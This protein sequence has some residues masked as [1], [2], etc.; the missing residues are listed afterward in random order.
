MEHGV[1][2]Q[3]PEFRIQKIGTQTSLCSLPS[4][5]FM[6]FSNGPRTTDSL[7]LPPTSNWLL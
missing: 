3:E 5:T 1:R 2:I 7:V 4:P 6:F